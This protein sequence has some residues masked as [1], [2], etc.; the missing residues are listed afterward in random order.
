MRALAA[1]N[2]PVAARTRFLGSF[3]RSAG[4][5]PTRGGRV[6]RP[7]LIIANSF[8]NGRKCLTEQVFPLPWHGL[9]D[10][11]P[12]ARGP[13]PHTGYRGLDSARSLLSELKRLFLFW[14]DS[15]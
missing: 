7:G 8:A 3:I 1:V 9:L 10:L 12:S 4:A 5:E 2:G 11:G 13:M 14:L 6:R 15:A